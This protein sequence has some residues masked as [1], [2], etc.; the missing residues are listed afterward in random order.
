MRHERVLREIRKP[1]R[2]HA[3][4]LMQSLV[5]AIQPL[6]VEELAEILA[7]DF[8][9]AEGIPKSNLN[10]RREDQEQAVLT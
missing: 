2:D 4:R 10:W 5:V 7:V 1:N 3:R 9:D 6:G 8:S